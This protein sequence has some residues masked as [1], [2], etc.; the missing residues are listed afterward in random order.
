MPTAKTTAQYSAG[1][2]AAQGA[3]RALFSKPSGKFFG[4]S[5]THVTYWLGLAFGGGFVK[6][7]SLSRR[8]SPEKRN[9]RSILRSS[10]ENSWDLFS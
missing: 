1:S 10:G 8:Y 3:T 7:I 2:A 4:R 5:I 9:S 6:T